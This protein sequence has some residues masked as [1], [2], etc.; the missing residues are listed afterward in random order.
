[1]PSRITHL[2][3]VFVKFI[4]RQIE[5][6]K[7]YVSKEYQV[8]RHNCACGCGANTVTPLDKEYGWKLT[9]KDGEISLSPSIGNQQF[10]CGSHYSIKKNQIV[11]H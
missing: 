8:A 6:G 5:D 2:E 7:L 10:P 4:P 1:M 11:W 3:P 9:E